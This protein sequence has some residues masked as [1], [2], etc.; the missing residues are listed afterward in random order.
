MREEKRIL[1]IIHHKYPTQQHIILQCEKKGKKHHCKINSNAVGSLVQQLF[2]VYFQ[3]Y[4]S[5][6]PVIEKANTLYR[7]FSSLHTSFRILTRDHTTKSYKCLVQ[8]TPRTHLILYV[9]FN[10]NKRNFLA[11]VYYLFLWYCLR[12][13]L[14]Q[15]SV[16][17]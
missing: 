11:C 7:L 6:L 9:A 14:I 16:N 15:V 8:W 13:D 5:G 3:Y 12:S 2:W 17:M 1:W 10:W 4:Y